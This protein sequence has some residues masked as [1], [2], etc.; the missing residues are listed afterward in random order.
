MRRGV[1]ADDGILQVDEDECGLF[2]VELEFCH[3]SSLLKFDFGI[4]GMPLQFFMGILTLLTY[5][6]EISAAACLGYLILQS[7]CLILQ[8]STRNPPFKRSLLGICTERDV[9]CHPNS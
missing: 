8:I 2:R 9:Q 6:Y 1:H 5:L 7:F 4:R 3:G